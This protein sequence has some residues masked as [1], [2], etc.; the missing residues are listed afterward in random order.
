MY[1]ISATINAPDEAA[2][3]SS[4]TVEVTFNISDLKSLGRFKQDLP[5]GF[6]AT[7]IQTLNG[8]FTFQD[9]ILKVVWTP[10][11]PNDSVFTISYKI[12]VDPTAEG[13]LVLGGTFSYVDDKILKSINLPTKTIIIKQPG[14]I[15]N[16]QQNNSNII[17]NL[18]TDKVFCYRQME[19]GID[20]ITVHL[21]VNTA[22][23]PKDKFGKVQEKIPAGYNATN[24][25]SK[26]GIFSFKDNNVKFLWMTLPSD[27]MYQISYKLTST[28]PTSEIP[29]ISGNFS[30]V[31][32]EGTVIKTIE[33]KEF[34][35]NNIL[36]NNQNNNQ[37]NNQNNNQTNNQNN[38]Q[39]NNQNN[40]Q[41]NNQNNNQTNNQNNN[42]T[43]NQNNNQ[44]NNQN[45]NQTNNQNN[46]QTNNQNNNQTNN[47]NNNQ[48]NN[49]NN[50]QTNNQN[51][52]I[53]TP[54]TG[55]KYKVQIGA[56][57]R[58][59]NVSYF[60][61]LQVNEPVSVELNNGLNKYLVGLHSEYKDAR[62]HREKV[63]KETPIRDAFV[64]AYNNGNR[65][66]VQEALM[67]ANQKWYQ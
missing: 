28:T 46:N 5:V 65:I 48:T 38:N 10:S 35:P 53:V 57:K 8:S 33:N 34:L 64:S 29:D 11:L 47:Q 44:T 45:N 37:T 25:E 59:L 55:V 43:N 61:K 60:K 50:N 63:W 1:D 15:A 32:N 54:E 7:P 22:N 26:D 23:L 6:K 19:R 52:N 16:N 4:F 41:T 39:T 56:Y 49:Q 3:G 31:E 27:N 21:L 58:Y 36:A 24:I 62:D 14:A 17:S 13:P 12:D 2:P 51:N 30:Y 9:Q 40:N 42:Q 20:G 66:T 67:I 18:P